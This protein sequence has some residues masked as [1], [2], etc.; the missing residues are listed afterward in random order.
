MRCA[1]DRSDWPFIAWYRSIPETGWIC[2]FLDDLQLQ[3]SLVAHSPIGR[4]LDP[5]TLDAA[6]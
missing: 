2:L 4:V 3:F 5:D 6:E 1:D